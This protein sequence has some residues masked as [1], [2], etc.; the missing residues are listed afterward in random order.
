MDFPAWRFRQVSDSDGRA[1]GRPTGENPRFPS[2]NCLAWGIFAEI[3]TNR[4]GIELHGNAG[5]R[6]VN[7]QTGQATA[8]VPI[9]YIQGA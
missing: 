1:D 2:D 4:L 7:T 3:I 9:G 5:Y 6:Y 8:I